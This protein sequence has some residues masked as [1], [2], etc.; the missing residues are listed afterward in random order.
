MGNRWVALVA[1]VSTTVVISHL[2]SCMIFIDD[3]GY[4]FE[5][6]LYM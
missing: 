2:R 5:N 6:T 3:I 4:E 1:W